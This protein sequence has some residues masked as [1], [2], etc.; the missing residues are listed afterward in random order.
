MSDSRNDRPPTSPVEALF[1]QRLSRQTLFRGAA[2]AMLGV[3]P[4]LAAACGGGSTSSTASTSAGQPKRGGVLRVSFASAGTAETL[5]PL[6][7]VTPI[8]QARIQSLYDPL[9][10]TNPDFSTSPGLALEWNP[11]SDAT[12]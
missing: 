6:I 3:S 7:A 5:S 4:L 9:I 1:D 12:V 11:N 8:D 10:I 2:G